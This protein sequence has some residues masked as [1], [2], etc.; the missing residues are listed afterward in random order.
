MAFVLANFKEVGGPG[1]SED[2]GQ[3]FS[4]WSDADTLGTML[5]SGYLNDVAY[6]LNV[7]DAVLLTGT[8]GCIVAQITSISTAATPVVTVGNA[9]SWATGAAT[10]ITTGTGTVVKQSVWREGLFIHTQIFIDLDGLRS[11]GADDII[12]VDGTSLDCHIG[13]ITLARNGVLFRGTMRC[14]EAPTG[15]DPDINLYANVESTG[16]ESDDPAGLTGTGILLNAGDWIIEEVLDIPTMPAANEFLYLVAGA[17]TDVEY[18]VGKLVID[19]WG[20]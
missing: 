14:L 7:R 12:G 2:G 3:V 17:A 10:G 20:T 16:S 19:F 13:Q 5:A 6:K 11:T 8:D 15:G 1:N 18:A 4:Q 9:A